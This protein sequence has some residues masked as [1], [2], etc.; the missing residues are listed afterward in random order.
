MKNKATTIVLTAILVTSLLAGMIPLASAQ[1]VTVSIGSGSAAKNENV[2][3]PLMIY[4]VTNLAAAVLN[5][6]YDESV[7]N[8]TNVSDSQFDQPPL[9]NKRGPGWVLLEAG[10]FM[11]GLDGDILMCNVTL[12]AVGDEGQISALNLTDIA[13]E[14]MSMVPIAVDVVVNGTFR[15]P[16]LTTG[17]ITINEIMYNPNPTQGDDTDMEWIELFN[18]DTAPINISGWEIDGNT[19]EDT[20]IQ[21]AG[22]AVLVRNETAFTGYYGSLSCPVIAADFVLTNDPGD[23]I[24]LENS[25]GVEIDNVP[26]LSAWGADG[27]NMTLELNATD[28]WEESITDGGT[29][30]AA[31]SVLG[32]SIFG[33]T[34]PENTWTNSSTPVIGANYSSPYGI[35]TTSVTIAVDGVDKTADVNTTITTTYVTYDNTS[36]ILSEGLHNA[37]VYAEDN[38]GNNATETWNFGVDPTPPDINLTSRQPADG[39]YLNHSDVTISVDYNCSASGLA[40]T[41]M[42]LN[43]EVADEAVATENNVTY[44]ATLDDGVYNVIVNVTDN[45]GNTNGTT[46]SFTVDTQPPTFTITVD[47]FNETLANVTVI[48]NKNLTAPPTVTADNSTVTQYVPMTAEDPATNITCTGNF[49][50]TT[51]TYLIN[52]TGMDRAQNEGEGNATLQIEVIQTF[53]DTNPVSVNASETAATNLTIRTSNTTAVSGAISVIKIEDPEPIT[54]VAINETGI[55]YMQMNASSELIADISNIT[56]TIRMTYTDDEVAGVNVSTLRLYCF[57]DT[58]GIWDLIDDSAPNEMAKYVEG[59][60]TGHFSIVGMSG[61]DDTPPVISTPQDQTVNQGATANITWNIIEANPDKYWVLRNGTVVVAPSSYANATDINVSINTT[62]VGFWNYT[63]VANDATGNEASDQVNVIIRDA[64]PP[65]WDT[66]VGIQ[67]A[68]DTGNGGEVTVTYGTASDAD[69]SPV[70]YN[71]YY[72]TSS[73]ATGGTKLSDVGSSP[74]TVT[75]LTNGQ[76]YYFMVRVEDSATPPNEDVNPIEL[77]AIPTAPTAPTPYRPGGGVRVPSVP[78]INVPVDPATGAVTSTTSL[79]VEKATLTIPAGAIIK[80]AAG[81]PL[82]TSITTMHT[83]STAKTVGAIAA[84]DFGPSGTRFSKPIDLV[85]AYD[86][87][88]IPAGMSESDLVVRMYDGTAKAWIDLD[89]SVDT[90]ARTATA[91]VSHFTIFALFT[92]AP[93]A[94]VTPTAKPTIPPTAVPTATPIPPV[95]PPVKSPWGLIIGIIVAVI[96]VGAA[97]YYVYTKKKA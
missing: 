93:P 76:S 94:V 31:N 5:L 86:P 67:S 78:A 28:E 70:K 55:K 4:N 29:P 62:T 84:Y 21:A 85:I 37:T 25:T 59:N 20:V 32:V 63:I 34:P 3:V 60:L 82:S 9:L 35:N 36:D 90:A 24:V 88:D 95:V 87:A 16:A 17:D 74:Y 6:T 26:Y 49:N 19:I 7:A 8:V 41:V 58:A 13:L 44:T 69:S 11:T 52:V 2:T 22:Y 96:I 46:W 72:R 89:T 97:A 92:A 48:A 81:D 38:Q 73:P 75:G 15:I 71:V 65:T 45:A 47:P 83:P 77:S 56:V 79:T 42:R 64:T 33:L 10:Q 30:C 91:K 14:N 23:T 53:N 54:Q 12:E 51:G 40:S 61:E 66:T 43:G 80:D 57:N 27:N 18:N 1:T 39:E 68:T 50:I